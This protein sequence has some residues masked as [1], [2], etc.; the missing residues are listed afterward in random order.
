MKITHK[1]RLLVYLFP[2]FMISGI[3][4]PTISVARALEM[5]LKAKSAILLDS[6]STEII[7]SLNEHEKLPPASITKIMTLLLALEAL[8]RGEITLQDKVPITQKAASMGGSQLFLSQGD[9]VDMES[10]LIGITVG[11]GND[12]A[13]AVAE[14]IAG[15][16]AAFVVLMNQRAVQLKMLNTNFVNPTGLHD[17]NHYSTAY[18][19]SLAGRELLDHQV[20]FNWSTIWMDEN[21]LEG[22]IKSGKVFLSNTNRM[23]RFYLGCDG[24]KTGYT[25]EAGHCTV[26]TAKRNDTRF[27]A[28]VLGAPD[29]DTRYFEAASLLDYAFANYKSVSLKDENELIAGLPVEKGSITE[30][31]VLTAEKVSFLQRKGEEKDYRYDILLP[32][33]LNA[34]LDKGE[35]VGEII[36]T[37]G[38]EI[39]KK[40]DLI[41]EQA[42]HNATFSQLLRRHISSWLT[43]GRK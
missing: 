9:V 26:A 33:H 37:Q 1:L 34:P 13:V 20:F 11:S 22:R 19:L 38:D 3:F 15:S 14:Y 4:C 27:I 35:K 10:L 16:E 5:D 7:Y 36:V 32:R 28:V 43:F 6:D 18:D 24:I 8:Q 41:V 25:R 17:D 2:L 12:A 39:L 30:V 29:S 31:N 23:V 21:F 40:V 42:V